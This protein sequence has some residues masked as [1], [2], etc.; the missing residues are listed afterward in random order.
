[1]VFGP[2]GVVLGSAGI[3]KYP[4]GIA[5]HAIQVLPV[6]ALLGLMTRWNEQHRVWTVAAACGGYVLITAVSPV[7]AYSG[8]GG[9][10]FSWLE[11]VA[12]IG[13]FAVL[14]GAVWSLCSRLTG[15]V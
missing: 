8:R 15:A 1:M 13:G 2:D 14:V 9:L 5:M 3:L 7:Q 12:V 6:I 11:I 10:M 4:H